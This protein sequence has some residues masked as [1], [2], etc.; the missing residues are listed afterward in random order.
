[1]GYGIR[2]DRQRGSISGLVPY[3]GGGAYA[4][5]SCRHH[6]HEG[7]R[8]EPDRTGYG[9]TVSVRERFATNRERDDQTIRTYP[10]WRRGRPQDVA[11]LVSYL[12]SDAASYIT[13][14]VIELDGGEIAGR[15]RPA[16]RTR[17]HPDT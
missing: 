4:A 13:G 10:D 15:Q 3:A 2:V 14:S 16:G 6:A 11:D 12:A 1:M 17:A 9:S 7:S 8:L 5:T